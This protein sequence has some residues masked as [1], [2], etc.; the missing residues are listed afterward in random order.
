MDYACVTFLLNVGCNPRICRILQT[1]GVGSSG[2]MRRRKPSTP[3]KARTEKTLHQFPARRRRP[4]IAELR[5]MLTG[6]AEIATTPGAAPGKRKKF[7]AAGIKRM[8]EAQRQRWAKIRGESEK[9]APTP[10]QA[11]KPKRKLSASA[12]A[13]LVANL[14]KARAAKAAKAKGA[15]KKSAPAR[16]KA[17][18]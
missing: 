14:K 12:K 9:P 16:K 6:S 18:I 3:K 4:S 8:S 10:A 15:A 1:I 2:S 11:P 13:K 5:T 17:I 7:S